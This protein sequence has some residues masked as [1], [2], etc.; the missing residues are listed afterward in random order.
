MLV[1]VTEIIGQVKWS[2]FSSPKSLQRLDDFDQASRSVTGSIKLLFVAPT[3]YL[4]VVGALITIVSLAIGPFTQQAIKTVPCPQYLPDTNASLPIA[5]FMP[6]RA[7]YYRVGAGQW[8]VDVDMKG[9]MVNGLVNPTGNDTAITAT[10]QTGNCTFPVYDGGITHSSIAMCSACIDT[11]SLVTGNED[12]TNYTMPNNLWIA[13][14]DRE[15][16]MNVIVDYNLTWASNLFGADFAAQS[17]AAITNI[18]I[19]SFTDAPCT[20]AADG[21]VSECPHNVTGY[22]GLSDYV[23]A[24]CA[25]YPCLKNYHAQISGSV[26]NETV[27]SSVPAPINSVEVALNPD[28]GQAGANYTALKSPCIL[29]G[30]LYDTSNFS[31][32]PDTA[33]SVFTGINFDGVNYTVPEECLYKVEW[34]Y[35]AAMGSFMDET[36]FTGGCVYDSAQGGSVYCYDS[37]WL[38]PLYNNRDGTFDMLNSQLDSFTTAITNKFRALG[39]SNDNGTS[40]EEALGT[41]M[42]TTVCMSF[43]WRWLLLPVGL[44]AATTAILLL[45]VVQTYLDPDQPVWKSSALPLIFHGFG[46]SPQAGP[47]P[48]MDIDQI[49][50]QSFHIKAMFQKGEDTGFVGVTRMDAPTRATTEYVS[51]ESLVPKGKNTSRPTI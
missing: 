41:V 8:E 2:Y 19:L 3:S 28:E 38:S 29:D 49:K 42:E 14:G 44:V 17:A 13:P 7:N 5:S 23:A 33:S 11:T 24:S 37:W 22:V 48:A 40:V 31:L 20:I 25:I 32:V 26:L 27:V 9:T 30:I 21:A 45:M 50:D 18:T 1:A 47:R 34:L 46:Y 43:D 12:G 6:G 15:P 10:C 35:A 39:S 4:A 16:Y 36:I 51:M